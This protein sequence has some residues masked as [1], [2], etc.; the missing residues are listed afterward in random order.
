M[1]RLIDNQRRI[2]ERLDRMERVLAQV[3]EYVRPKGPELDKV[4]GGKEILLKVPA[5]LRKTLLALFDL[6]EATA[7]EIAPKTGRTRGLESIYLNQLER[8]KVVEKFRK[9]RK[10]LFRLAKYL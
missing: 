9:G 4:A 7:S 5:H 6:G 3:L 10:V 2:V 8:M 1:Q